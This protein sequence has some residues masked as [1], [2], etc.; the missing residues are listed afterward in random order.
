MIALHFF[1]GELTSH[2]LFV[3]C[4]ELHYIDNDFQQDS[5]S[6]IN[7]LSI[8]G[9]FLDIYSVGVKIISGDGKQLNGDADV[10][11]M[12]IDH[13]GI[14]DIHVYVEEDRELDVVPFR[15]PHD[16]ANP[17]IY[18]STLLSTFYHYIYH[19]L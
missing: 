5:S 3:H 14:S 7:I 9:K 12:F 4:G 13:K 17:G 16:N 2:R 18:L 11:A 8:C 15:L 19:V 1:L 10:Y 6:F